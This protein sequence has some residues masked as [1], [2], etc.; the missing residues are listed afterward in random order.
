MKVLRSASTTHPRLQRFTRLSTN[1]SRF[2][3]NRAPPKDV[4][5]TPKC[6]LCY[7]AGRSDKHFLSKCKYVPEHDKQFMAR[8]RKVICKILVMMI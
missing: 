7:Q 5:Y 6:P 2:Q 1:H 4:R 3:Y 8:A